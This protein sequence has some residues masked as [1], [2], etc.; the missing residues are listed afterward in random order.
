M[1]TFLVLGVVIMSPGI[2]WTA[3]TAYHYSKMS[4]S[5]YYAPIHHLD[6]P[7]SYPT[8][9]DCQAYCDTVA[10][11]KTVEYSTTANGYQKPPI[12]LYK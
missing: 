9:E 11:C 5:Y 1:K 10:A 8:P 4:G 6:G 7:H 3:C 12:L 2:V